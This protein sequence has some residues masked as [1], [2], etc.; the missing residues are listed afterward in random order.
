V[1]CG[2]GIWERG[3][4]EAVF[5][6]VARRNR[7][8]MATRL[9]SWEK[10]HVSALLQRPVSIVVSIQHVV[11]RPEWGDIKLVGEV[12]GGPEGWNNASVNHT[13]NAGNAPV[14]VK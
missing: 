10:G 13:S 11:V 12:D 6:H 5:G 9:G 7:G 2:E 3:Q 1:L 14:F 4:L 8:Q